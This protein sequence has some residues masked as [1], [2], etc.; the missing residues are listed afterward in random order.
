MLARGFVWPV[1]IPQPKLSALDRKA[2][3]MAREA[4]MRRSEKWRSYMKGYRAGRRA[5]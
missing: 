1:V 2:K 3:A 5:K 4:F